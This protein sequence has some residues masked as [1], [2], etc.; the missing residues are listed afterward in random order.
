MTEYI[1]TDV[2]RDPH[3]FCSRYGLLWVNEGKGYYLLDEKLK[4]LGDTLYE[5]VRCFYEEGAAAVYQNGKWGFA[6]RQG[7]LVISYTFD[8]ADSYQ[9]GYAPVRQGGLWGYV[10]EDGN[11]LIEYAFDEALGFNGNGTAPVKREGSW[12]LIKLGI[13]E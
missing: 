7:Q 4:P 12:E 11:V 9:I 13:Y 8:D 2:K 5:D 10:A 6:D 3:N 1:Y